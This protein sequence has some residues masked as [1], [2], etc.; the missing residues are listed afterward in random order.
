MRAT[1]RLSSPAW[2]AAPQC[3]SSIHR[4]VDAAAGHQPAEGVGRQVVG[5]DVGQA[6]PD[7]PGGSAAG[8]DDED[9]GHGA[10]PSLGAGA[11]P[12]PRSLYR[13]AAAAS[14]PCSA[15]ISAHSGSMNR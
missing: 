12:G 5:S 10:P 7:L 6:A 3:T 8:I 15:I 4:R 14:E 1:L 11:G 9:R 13:G 2:L